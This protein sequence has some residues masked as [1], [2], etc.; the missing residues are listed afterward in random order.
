MMLEVF[1]PLPNCPALLSPQH[2]RAPLKIAH[3]WLLPDETACA[4][5]GSAF[6]T[7]G[8][9]TLNATVPTTTVVTPINVF[10]AIDKAATTALIFE[11]EPEF[12]VIAVLTVRTEVK[13]EASHK[14]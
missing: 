8:D 9:K 2:R 3:E 1:V 7:G 4:G 14:Q 13:V 6:A 5:N 11:P 10:V 12:A